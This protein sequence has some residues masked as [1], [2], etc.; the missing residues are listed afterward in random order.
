MILSALAWYVTVAL[1]GAV[2]LGSLRR[3]GLGTG[4]SWAVARVSVWTV[5]GYVAWIV[6][7]TGVAHWW[8]FGLI[9]LVPVGWWGRREFAGLNLKALIEPEL[10]GLGAFLLL[11]F[12]RLSAMSVTAT[13]KPMDLAI[14]STLLRPGTIPRSTRGWPARPSRTTTGGSFPGCSPRGCS[15][16]YPTSPSTCWSRRSPRFPRR[17]RGRS[18]APSAAAAAPASWPRSWLSLSG[19]STGGGSSSA[20]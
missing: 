7:W 3:L 16:S 14:L 10:V 17:R 15:A 18:L 12:L 20:A 6:G 19:R 9:V 1:G 13:E 11:G 8:W 4:A 5:A 2:A